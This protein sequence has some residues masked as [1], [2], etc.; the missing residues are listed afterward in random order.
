MA[1]PLRDTGVVTSS[2][3]PGVAAGAT[4]I[5]PFAP[6]LGEAEPARLPMRQFATICNGLGGKRVPP[7]G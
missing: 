6:G 4:M 3:V 2:T 1:L 7:S 5:L